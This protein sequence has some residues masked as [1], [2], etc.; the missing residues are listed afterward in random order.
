MLQAG[1][2]VSDVQ[3]KIFN[4]PPKIE[5]ALEPKRLR[6]DAEGRVRIDGLVSG[7]VLLNAVVMKP[8][9]DQTSNVLPTRWESRWAT[10]TFKLR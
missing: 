6:T 2:P 8:V 7:E 9:P 4:R 1:R 10:V 3:V 5:S